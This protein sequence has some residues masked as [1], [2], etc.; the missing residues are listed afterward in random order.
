MPSHGRFDGAWRDRMFVILVGVL[1]GFALGRYLEAHAGFE[2]A[3]LVTM[4]LGGILTGVLARVAL[5][6][7]RPKDGDQ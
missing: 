7:F 3:T 6:R 1:L 4:P 2:N 5:D